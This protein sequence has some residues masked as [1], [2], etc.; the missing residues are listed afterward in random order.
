VLLL[1]LFSALAS[2]ACP[3]TVT[4]AELGARVQA[5]ERSWAQADAVSFHR[6]IAVVRDSVPCV[7]QVLT[8]ADVVAIHEAEALDHFL[9]TDEA[10]TR[11]DFAALH[12]TDPTWTLPAA[13]VP[14]QH[15]LRTWLAEAAAHTDTL[16]PLPPAA[17]G[18]LLVDG[19]PGAHAPTNRPYVLQWTEG[20]AV[21]LTVHVDAGDAPPAPWTTSRVAETPL[22]A[23]E[24]R[25]TIAGP[26][27]LAGGAGA[28]LGG[29]ALYIGVRQ[30]AATEYPTLVDADQAAYWQEDLRPRWMASV[31]L[32]AGGGLA[33]AAGSA[34]TLTAH[35][36][37][38]VAVSGRW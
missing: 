1:S 28:G 25:R 5:A 4:T 8:P 33:L 20:D 14:Q 19:R 11:L 34:V 16:A 9:Q 32:M 38:G 17:S 29:L 27:L 15:P 26:A 23:D 31:A 13:L 2:A 36:G 24:P 35:Q 21:R 3:A 30:A 10:R 22:A 18:T 7:G 37:P 6:D 12:A